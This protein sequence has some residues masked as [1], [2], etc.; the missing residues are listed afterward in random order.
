LLEFADQTEQNMFFWAGRAD[1][2]LEDKRIFLWMK[3]KLAKKGVAVV[4]DSEVVYHKLFN[5][6][7]M[8]KVEFKDPKIRD[9]FN[10]ELHKLLTNG[11]YEKI[12]S[13]AILE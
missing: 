5:G 7:A 8:F 3:N 1:A 2:V 6:K 12:V 4:P 11:S 10:V 13:A 9:A